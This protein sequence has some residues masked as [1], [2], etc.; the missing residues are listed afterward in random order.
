MDNKETVAAFASSLTPQQREYIGAYIAMQ[1]ENMVGDVIR[2]AKTVE[3][4]YNALIDQVG[5]LQKQVSAYDAKYL[6]DASYSLTRPK[7]IALMKAE[8]IE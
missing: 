8:G 1:V 6:D 3:E 4:N 2:Y 7:I 5:I